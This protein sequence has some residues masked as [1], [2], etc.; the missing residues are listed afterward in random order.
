MVHINFIGV[1]MRGGGV[2]M[3]VIVI[4][5]CNKLCIGDMLCMY[6]SLA[7]AVVIMVD[8]NLTSKLI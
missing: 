6:V 3:C 8:C 5:L 2:L 1:I 4:Y 7:I